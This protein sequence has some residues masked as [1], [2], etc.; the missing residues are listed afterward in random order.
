MEGWVCGGAGVPADPWQVDGGA[1]GWSPCFGEA[2][3]AGDAQP[4]AGGDAGMGALGASPPA[5][6]VGVDCL[7]LLGDEPEAES[8][9]AEDDGGA[10]EDPDDPPE[11]DDPGC[12]E[13]GAGEDDDV[14]GAPA[15]RSGRRA[16]ACL[17]PPPGAR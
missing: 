4:E 3:G 10:A 17:A 6:G 15:G 7:G 1:A 16:G 11:E 14:P 8:S 12:S 13:P 9:G 2:D 5:G